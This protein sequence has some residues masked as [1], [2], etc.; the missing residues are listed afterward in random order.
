MDLEL[1]FIPCQKR[2]TRKKSWGTGF[3]RCSYMV[4]R[5]RKFFPTA[6]MPVLKLSACLTDSLAV[7][8]R[9]LLVVWYEGCHLCNM[10][11]PYENGL[12][13]M[14]HAGAVKVKSGVKHGCLN[15]LNMLRKNGLPYCE[16][17]FKHNIS[18]FWSSG[19][20]KV[21]LLSKAVKFS[22]SFHRQ[23]WK[24]AS[25]WIKAIDQIKDITFP[26]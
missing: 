2:K 21:R 24:K 1:W 11:V 20:A 15:G 12:I 16:M 25:L 17:G 23:Q 3:S 10:E 22:D 14:F 4:L 13:N 9:P 7:I 5:T 8:P 26:S 19:A 6:Q 18:A